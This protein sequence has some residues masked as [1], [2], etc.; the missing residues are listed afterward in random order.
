MLP[1]LASTLSNVL[2]AMLPGVLLAALLTVPLTAVNG[3]V[4]YFLFI[5][6]H[7]DG[8]RRGLVTI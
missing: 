2:L 7:A 5:S 1:V 6:E 3:A 4:K 8:E